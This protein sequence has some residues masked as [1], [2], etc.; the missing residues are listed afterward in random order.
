MTDVISQFDKIVNIDKA[1]LTSAGR[2][3]SVQILKINDP[4]D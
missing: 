3:S 1:D 2:T 4:L